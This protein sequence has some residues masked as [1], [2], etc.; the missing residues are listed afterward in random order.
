AEELFQWGQELGLTWGAVRAPEDWLVDPH[1]AARGF[2]AEVEHPELERR[3]AYPGAPFIAPASPY[4][5]RRRAPLVGED[6]AAVYPQL[7]L[8]DAELAALGSRGIV[9][10][11]HR[12]CPR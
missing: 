1:V 11:R 10:S 9:S 12:S 5:I 6:N 2:L 3:I 8:S 4:R 7:G